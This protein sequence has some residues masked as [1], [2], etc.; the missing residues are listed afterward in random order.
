MYIFLLVK[1]PNSI[2]VQKKIV[3]IGYGS[4]QKGYELYHPKTGQTSVHRSVVL[5]E[6]SFSDRAPEE[7]LA[8][9]LE[10][11]HDIDIDYIED[12]PAESSE[13]EPDRDLGY[14]E[15]VFVHSS[16]PEPAAGADHACSPKEY[17]E[18][19]ETDPLQK[20]LRNAKARVTAILLTDSETYVM[21]RYE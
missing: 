11:E 12:S 3:F 5:N 14:T 2:I 4:S 6:N 19:E 18:S 10:P 21:N 17:S 9:P 8:E 1:G 15:D 7:G 20:A 13:S 16:E